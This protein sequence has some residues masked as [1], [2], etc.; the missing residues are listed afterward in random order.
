MSRY[1]SSSTMSSSPKAARISFV[2]S[3]CAGVTAGDGY[4]A[5]TP[6]PTCAGVFGIA[7]TIAGCASPVSSERIVAPATIESTSCSALSFPWSSFIT[8]GSTCGFTERTTTAASLAASELEASAVIANCFASSARRS[9]RGP[10]T[11]TCD[12]GTTWRSRTARIIAAPITPPPRNAIRSFAITE[13]WWPSR[14]R[15][16]GLGLSGQFG[17]YLSSGRLVF[18]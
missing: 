8:A 9:R 3:R 1:D 11:V 6:I 7:R 17:R 2:R 15:P 12:G 14:E 5:V 10:V 18:Y 4:H 13:L 16:S